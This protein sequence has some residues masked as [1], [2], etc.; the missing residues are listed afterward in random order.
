ME[1]LSKSSSGHYILPVGIVITVLEMTSSVSIYVYIYI[2]IYVCIYEKA[3][4]RVKVMEE[5]QEAFGVQG[6]G[7]EDVYGKKQNEYSGSD[8]MI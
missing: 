1:I 4:K 6:M 8:L 5:L 3:T 7:E 2:Y